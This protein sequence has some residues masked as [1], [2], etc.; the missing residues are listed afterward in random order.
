MAL[1]KMNFRQVFLVE[2]IAI[3]INLESQVRYF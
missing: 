1:I 2:W 3:N